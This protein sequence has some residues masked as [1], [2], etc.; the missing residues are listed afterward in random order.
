MH[1]YYLKR[2]WICYIVSFTFAPLGSTILEPNLEK[3]AFAYLEKLSNLFHFSPRSRYSI[4]LVVDG[5]RATGSLEKE[6]GKEKGKV[7]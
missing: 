3:I 7:M 2:F 1:Y 6:D 5:K 4:S